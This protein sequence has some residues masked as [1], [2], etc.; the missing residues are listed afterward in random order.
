MGCPSALQAFQIQGSDFVA[1]FPV[2]QW[3]VKKVRH[4][5]LPPSHCVAQAS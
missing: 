3:L 2:V 4:E 1:I 5:P